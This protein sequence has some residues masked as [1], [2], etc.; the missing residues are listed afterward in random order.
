MKKFTFD[1][2]QDALA[3]II[4]RH[5]G[6]GE[7]ARIFT[8]TAG[9]VVH[10]WH[11][12]IPIYE[13][14]LSAFRNTPVRLLEIGVVRGGGLRLW[15]EYLGP[16]ATIFGIDINPAC[17]Q[18]DGHHGQVRIGSQ[19]DHDF[20]GRVVEE[21]GGVD[22]VIDDGSH[23]M[24]HIR[25]S[26]DFLLPRLDARGL[27][28]IED[29]HTAYWPRWG[30][31][32]DAEGNFFNVIR[33]M[34][35]DMHHWYHRGHRQMAFARD[36]ITGIHVH[37][38]MVVIERGPVSR[39]VHS[40]QGG[41][42]PVAAT[43]LPQAPAAAQAAD[44]PADP[45]ETVAECYGVVIPFLPVLGRKMITSLAAGTYERNEILC[46]IETIPAKS[47]VLEL[48][49]G[50]GVVGAVIARNC[51]PEAILSFEANPALL[52]HI[53][54]THRHNGLEGKIS[55]R[56]GV[57]LTEPD[58]PD[59][60]DFL[61][62]G[63]F[64]GSGLNVTG[65]SSRVS[66]PV[67]RYATIAGAF[68]HNVIVMDI[69]GG[70]LGFLTHA[71]LTGIDLFI[72]EFHPRLYGPEGLQRCEELLAASGLMLDRAASRGNVRVHRRNR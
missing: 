1:P 59:M 5:P 55:V 44:L 38:S 72:A 3:D 31:G 10:K 68:P 6:A 13:R 42:E 52:P 23:Q 37:D 24:S 19:A 51:N 43:A 9:P 54:T 56:H 65:K 28:L 21:M 41:K 12:Y 2:T 64:L 49:A 67:A 62:R 15:R 45:A 63:N 11:H 14:Y 32:L 27:Y 47:R 39:P 25:A 71:D 69:E 61:V 29:L 18:H 20:L 70:E 36:L 30:G 22:V 53:A 35:D 33:K 57:V 17:Q 8:G 34:I 48:G 60:V 46:S 50:I 66:V 58:A 7:L 40:M 16:E 26:L 4:A